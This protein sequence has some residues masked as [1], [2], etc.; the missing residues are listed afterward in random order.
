MLLFFAV[1]IFM[2]GFAVWKNW[3]GMADQLSGRYL[4]AHPM[5]HEETWKW[6]MAR[7][8]GLMFMTFGCL[9]A[10]AFVY[11]VLLGAG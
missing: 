7:A 8:F 11:L 10:I 2:S 6:K 9:M 1:V 4:S 3:W 5:G